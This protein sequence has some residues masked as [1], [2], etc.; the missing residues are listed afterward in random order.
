MTTKYPQKHSEVQKTDGLQLSPIVYKRTKDLKT[1]TFNHIFDSLKTTKYFLDLSRD[2]SKNGII[3]PLICLSDGTLIE[4]HSRLRI[5]K[6]LEIEKVPVRIILTALSQDEIKSRVY[7]GNLNRFEI[8]IATRKML[9]ADLYPDY[10]L[11][12][13]SAGATVAPPHTVNEISK[14]LGVS[15]RTV[16][17]TRAEL[18]AAQRYQKKGIPL[19]T[20]LQSA[21]K[22]KNE[23]RRNREQKKKTADGDWDDLILSTIKGMSKRAFKNGVLILVRHAV[24]QR[25]LPAETL[26][27]ARNLCGYD[28]VGNKKKH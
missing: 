3:N 22:S 1:N 28:K 15:T 18:S 19:T 21:L 4:G 20:A 14:N 26:I 9:W 25:L 12:R 8:N 23:E 11:S 10:F 5:A 13:R 24:E 27:N 17:N 16:Q 7:L 6:K 2:I